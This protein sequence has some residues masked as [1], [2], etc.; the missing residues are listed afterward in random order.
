MLLHLFVSVLDHRFRMARTAACGG[1]PRRSGSGRGATPRRDHCSDV[2]SFSFQ[3]LAYSLS[4]E[5]VGTALMVVSTGSL[6][7]F[8]RCLI[9]P[10]LREPSGSNAE[11]FAS[12]THFRRAAGCTL[13]C[14]SRAAHVQQAWQ[15]DFAGACSL[16][17]LVGVFGEASRQGQSRDGTYRMT[18]VVS[19]V[20]S[21]SVR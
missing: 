8:D 1:T 18:L 9:A 20:V 19:G 6:W 3:H 17:F 21:I 4:F 14:G 15:I 13:P 11:P 2:K 16:A 12:M 10:L 7:P 5:T